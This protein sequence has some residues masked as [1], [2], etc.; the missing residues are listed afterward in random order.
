MIEGQNNPLNL[1]L[2]L[3][4]RITR[5]YAYSR[6]WCLQALLVTQAAHPHHFAKHCTDMLDTTPALSPLNGVFS[7]SENIYRPHLVLLLGGRGGGS[8]DCGPTSPDL[9]CYVFLWVDGH[10]SAYWRLSI[11]C[12]GVLMLAELAFLSVFSKT[13]KSCII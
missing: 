5:N 7:Y 3:R 1:C 12:N 2:S 6:C 9:S 11:D 13:S 8:K 10:I 4:T